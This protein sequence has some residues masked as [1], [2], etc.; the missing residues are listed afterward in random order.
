MTTGRAPVRRWDRIEASATAAVGAIAF[1]TSA[2]F[3]SRSPVSI[4]TAQQLLTVRECFEFGRCPE[5]GSAASV[6]GLFHGGAGSLALQLLGGSTLSIPRIL[7][8]IALGHALATTALY[9][10][11]RRRAPA[12]STTPIA[13]AVVTASLGW[14]ALARVTEGPTLWN[15]S[16]TALPIAGFVLA[17]AY[18]ARRTSA[19][20]AALAGAA[21]G[22]A[23]SLHLSSLLAL[24]FAMIAT[25]GSWRR[26]RS[27]PAFLLTFGG[28]FL[29]ES[30]DAAARLGEVAVAR[31]GPLSLGVGLSLWIGF[32]FVYRHLTRR[33]PRYRVITTLACLA[34]PSL[35]LMLVAPEVASARYHGI[36][37]L[38]LVVLFAEVGVALQPGVPSRRTTLW[39]ASAVLWVLVLGTP[40]A[41]SLARAAQPDVC[42]SEDTEVLANELDGLTAGY[43]SLARGARGPGS[44]V[45][46]LQ[47]ATARPLAGVGET[48]V[49]QDVFVACVP[50]T[51]ADAAPDGYTRVPLGADRMGLLH[52]YDGRVVTHR[53]ELCLPGARSRCA[54]GDVDAGA[55]LL[56]QGAAALASR[57]PVDIAHALADY[58]AVQRGELLR[59]RL[60]IT[61]GPPAAVRFAPGTRIDSVDGVEGIVEA[62]DRVTLSGDGA[63]SI[64]V[65]VPF[66]WARFGYGPPE[67]A[68]VPVAHTHWLNALPW[69]SE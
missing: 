49:Q 53:F 40:V 52:A 44:S 67:L 55:V 65:R 30:R 21:L 13:L 16:F 33:S 25:R 51:V 63:G 59:F 8:G 15:P 19:L 12:R 48:P 26:P 22:L 45:L 20:A 50:S 57:L 27:L 3:W 42:R 35:V 14:L 28:A 46:A 66:D 32:A 31:A 64:V 36:A 11:V 10:W 2:W 60:P 1:L 47:L 68:E 24:P 43:A 23:S 18:R 58:G 61:A 69:S 9:V 4:D 7:I 62:P 29:F 17:L 56:E 6:S 54:W 5:H 34:L 41:G 39:I 38:A 37:L